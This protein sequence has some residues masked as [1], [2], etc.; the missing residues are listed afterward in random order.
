MSN[1]TAPSYLPGILFASIGFSAFSI[2][3]V[4]IKYL[5]DFYTP[6]TT[7]FFITFFASL[8]MIS[9]SPKLGGLK[10]TFRSK[11]L[12]WHALRGILAL[13][14]FSSVLGMIGISIGFLKAPAA[15][16]S[17]VHYVQML[18]GAFFG[19]TVFGDMPDIWTLIG[20]VI[21]IASGIRLIQQEKGRIPDQPVAM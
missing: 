12:K 9:L 17:P 21:I 15:I 11:K 4:G 2:G 20:S 14:G 18:W 10:K 13:V 1:N 8:F 6:F 7:A 16:V 19:Y 3:D 5:G